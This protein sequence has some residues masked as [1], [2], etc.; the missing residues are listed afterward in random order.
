MLRQTDSPGHLCLCSEKV[1]SFVLGEKVEGSVKN[2][3]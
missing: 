1:K 3:H 2:T